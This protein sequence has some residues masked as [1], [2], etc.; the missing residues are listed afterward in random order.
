MKIQVCSKHDPGVI[1]GATPGDQSLTYAYM[2]TYTCNFKHLLVNYKCKSCNIVL[3]AS[4]GHGH[5]ILF[6]P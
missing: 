2:S 1:N 6:K 3:V 4:L 5:S